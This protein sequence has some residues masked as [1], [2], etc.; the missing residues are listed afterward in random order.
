M[1]K[2]IITIAAAFVLVASSAFAV[3]G[4]PDGGTGSTL[5]NPT[6]DIQV[7]QPKESA[8]PPADV[9]TGTYTTEHSTGGYT[10][11]AQPPAT[12]ESTPIK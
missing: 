3:S 1:K 4:T 6:W 5:G 10:P 2:K 7:T 11:P 9:S 8:G 12:T